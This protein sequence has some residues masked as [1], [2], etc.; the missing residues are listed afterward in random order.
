MLP[1]DINTEIMA[2]KDEDKNDSLDSP[3]QKN[4]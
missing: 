4:M 2:A 3:N 1:R